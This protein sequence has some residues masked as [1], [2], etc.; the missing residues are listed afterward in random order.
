MQAGSFVGRE[1]PGLARL[2]APCGA[3]VVFTS[4][5]ISSYLGLPMKW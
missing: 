2:S 5:T 4:W 3:L 1:Q